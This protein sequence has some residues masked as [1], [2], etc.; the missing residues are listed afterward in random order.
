M[1]TWLAPQPER[2]VTSFGPAPRQVRQERVDLTARER[3][4]FSTVSPTYFLGSR[5][6]QSLPKILPRARSSLPIRGVCERASET[7]QGIELQARRRAVER[8]DGRHTEDA[9]QP[10]G[11][12]RYNARES[13]RHARVSSIS[14]AETMCQHV[15]LLPDITNVEGRQHSIFLDSHKG[16]VEQPV[17]ALLRLAD[18]KLCPVA[19]LFIVRKN[20]IGPARP[21]RDDIMRLRVGDEVQQQHDWESLAVQQVEARNE[22]YEIEAGG[23]PP[24]AVDGVVRRRRDAEITV[25]CDELI[26]RDGRKTA[27]GLR[28][29]GRR[30]G[31]RHGDGDLHLCAEELR[32]CDELRAGEVEVCGGE[33]QRRS[34][35]RFEA[36]AQLPAVERE[37]SPAAPRGIRVDLTVR[38]EDES[39][40]A[41]EE[42]RLP[43]YERELR[44]RRVFEGACVA[45]V[46]A[47]GLHVVVEGHLGVNPGGVE[48]AALQLET[49]N[50]RGLIR[51]VCLFEREVFACEEI[52][53]GLVSRDDIGEAAGRQSQ[54]PFKLFADLA[55]H[56]EARA[57]SK[58]LARRNRVAENGRVVAVG[59]AVQL[60]IKRFV[61][62]AQIAAEG[63]RAE[64][65]GDRLVRLLDLLFGACD[66]LFELNCL[67]VRSTRPSVRPRR[68]LT[69]VRA[70]GRISDGDLCPAAR[71]LLRLDARA[72]LDDETRLLGEH[73][74]QAF[75]LFALLAQLDAYL[76]QLRRVRRRVAGGRLGCG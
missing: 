18:L 49:G 31:D 59:A 61:A 69:A 9:E 57:Q 17:S 19:V 47:F 11:T 44:E 55:A 24:V 1:D 16:V 33:R 25:A 3:T 6:F 14:D 71:S 42:R 28:R 23:E 29:C 56:A 10:V 2:V 20:Q 26:A 60:S 35:R 21:C 75:K 52:R 51:E 64:L 4:K 32:R 12:A 8:T 15:G 41:F 70:V 13:E 40:V 50:A 43:C 34:L 37:V 30:R 67:R 58:T 63:D 7:E 73:R 66:A 68:H 5:V 36:G 39:R 62:E 74:S 65:L 48:L 72:Q 53:E 54:A 45:F 27:D 76:F 38:A 22:V 46:E